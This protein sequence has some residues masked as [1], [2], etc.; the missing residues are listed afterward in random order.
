MLKN[1][2]TTLG[3]LIAVF[4]GVLML[5]ASCTG[6]WIGSTLASSEDTTGS[7]MIAALGVENTLL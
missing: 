5:L 7:T 4:V 6:F 2:F 1:I 3:L